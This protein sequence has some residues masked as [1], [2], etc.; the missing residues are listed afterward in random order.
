MMNRTI[1]KKLKQLY[2]LAFCLGALWNSMAMAQSG[3]T[4]AATE[5]QLLQIMLPANAQRVLPQSVPTEI[6]QTLAKVTAA[7]N[8]KF[9]RGASEVLVWGGDSYQKA[10]ASRIVNRLTGSLKTAGWQYSVEGEEGGVTVFTALKES[11]HR[12]VVGL[13]G[14]TDEALIF[15][16]MEILPD[17]GNGNGVG[18]GEG[19]QHQTEADSQTEQQQPV[20]VKPA[21]TSSGGDSI[22]GEWSNG[23]SSVV[24]Y[25]PTVGPPSFT[26][27]KS[28]VW[29][30]NFHPNGTY[31]FSGLMQITLAGCTTT[32]FQDKR[33]RYTINGN[34]VTLTLTKN[35]WR[36]G[37]SCAA[38]GNMEKEGEHTPET[39][40]FSVSRNENGKEQVCL[41]S[42][43]E[44]GLV[45]YERAK[46]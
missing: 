41:D 32:Y 20:T 46:K 25:T 11:P 2:A 5:S 15:A 12:A 8:G 30:Y 10:N 1:I 43:G 19:E 39:Y 35:L 29:T 17:K 27:S 4:E 31:E 9:R 44:G 7:G 21:R 38:S 34:Q 42:G 37:E 14:A 22:L 24:G 16:A 33:G 26:P 28:R 45:C 3:D 18:N 13:Y 36:K 23:Y 40:T 6:T